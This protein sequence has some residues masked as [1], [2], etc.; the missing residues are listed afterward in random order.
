MS[1]ENVEVVQAAFEAW[2]ALRW[3]L[4]SSDRGPV[5]RA[6][7]LIHPEIVVDATRNVFNPA[8]YV[9][10]EG[11]RR[12]QADTGEVWEEVRTERLEFIDAGD[13]I[14]VIGMLV[15]KG[16]AS[17][18]QVDQPVAQIVTVRDSRVVRWELGYTDRRE[19]L[20]AVGLS[21][22]DAHADS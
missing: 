2:D 19:A 22:Q 3:D 15:G 13:R 18:V 14:V 4:G 6:L 1:Q 16:K 7:S 12:M 21:E 20:E 10:M 8:T 9:G 17:G 11:L 5:E